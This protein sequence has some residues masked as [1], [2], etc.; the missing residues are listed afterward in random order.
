MASGQTTSAPQL[1]LSRQAPVVQAIVAAGTARPVEAAAPGTSLELVGLHFGASKGRAFKVEVQGVPILDAQRPS[2]ERIRFTLPAGVRTGDVTLEVDGVFAAAKPLRVVRSVTWKK[3]AV[4]MTAGATADLHVLL[5]VRDSEVVAVVPVWDGGQ[6]VRR[7]AELTFTGDGTRIYVGS[8]G[9]LQALSEGAA[10][11]TVTAGSLPPRTLE[12]TI[13][14]SGS[15]DPSTD[16][17]P[18][19]PE[20]PRDPEPGDDGWFKPVVLPLDSNGGRLAPDDLEDALTHHP[21]VKSKQGIK[22]SFVWIP[23]FRAFQLIRPWQ[24]GAGYAGFPV[25]YWVARK[26]AQG[27]AEVDWAGETFGGFYAGMYEASREDSRAG[28]GQDGVPA[29]AG[30]SSHLKVAPESIPWTGISWQQAVTACADYDPAC[31]LMGDD[32]WTALAVWSMITGVTVRGNNHYLDD[33]EAQHIV[34]APDPTDPNGRALTGTGRDAGQTFA[35]ATNPTTHTGLVTGVY[36]LHGNVHEWTATLGGVAGA[37]HYQL[38]GQFVPV[39]MPVGGEIQSLSPH[40][41]VRR[42][43]V[44][45]STSL[46]NGS[47]PTGSFGGDLFPASTAQLAEGTTHALRGGCWS[48]LSHS[49]IWSLDLTWP[50]SHMSGELVGFRPVL[51]Y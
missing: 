39:A 10:T 19:D 38:L 6:L 45:E 21:Y 28:N 3:L 20:L 13:L 33:V 41:L 50:G 34:F 29:F 42:Y 17:T 25:G 31:H 11:V 32:E 23:R 51:R 15:S 8:D 43:G 27:E 35:V 40:R 30:T 4:T 7:P 48:G 26:P 49:G 24:C 9:V 16:P 18:V 47:S 5:D 22:S 12:L 2:D 1:V 44:P 36:D 37:S 14:A 46:G